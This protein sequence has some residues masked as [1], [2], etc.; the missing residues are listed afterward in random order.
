ML[1]Y[2]TR[3]AP[4]PRRVRIYLAEKGLSVPTTEVDLGKLEHKTDDFRARNP[5]LQTPVLLLDDGLALSETMAICR[6]F[7]EEHPEPPLFGVGARGKAVV[8]MWQRRVELGLFHSVQHVFRHTHPA[9]AALENPQLPAMA[10][11][12]RPRVFSFLEMLDAELATRPFVAGEGFSVADITAF[13]A[14]EFMR[15]ARLRLPDT[16][17]NVA[18][19]RA[20]VA[21]RPSAAA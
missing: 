18:S 12:Y 11:I 4:N 21:A 5:V 16:L 20:S 1:L 9:M 2:D 19:W 13:V 15:P 17:T 3:V 6:Y 7:E 10:D 8:E 14:V